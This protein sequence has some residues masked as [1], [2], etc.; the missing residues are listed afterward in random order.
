[1]RI[2][3]I[4]RPA[5]LRLIAAL[6]GLWI[7][8]IYLSPSLIGRR[9]LVPADLWARFPPWGFSFHEEAR[10]FPSNEVLYDVAWNV[11]PLIHMDRQAYFSGSWPL[12]NPYFRCGAPLL[13]NGQ[14]APFAPTN[15]PHWFLPWPFGFAFA[16]LARMTIAWLGAWLLGR[17]L[18]LHAIWASLLGLG[19]LFCPGL[20]SWFQH[21]NANVLIWFP[22][23]LWAAERLRQ[24]YATVGC[25][26]AAT[27]L[28]VIEGIQLCGGHFHSSFNITFATT[29][30][31]LIRFPFR[32]AG[33]AV[34][35]R[36]AALAALACGGILAAPAL[37]PAAEFLKGSYTMLER[38]QA[39][40]GQGNWVLQPRVFQLLL[41]PLKF[42]NQIRHSAFPWTGPVNWCVDQQYIGGAPWAL[43]LVGL[44]SLGIR[45]FRKAGLS[46]SLLHTL[47]SLLAMALI[48]ASMAYGWKPIQG[49]LVRVPP[50]S[51]NTNVH[52]AFVAQATVVIVGCL[53]GH[54]V[55]GLWSPGKWPRRIAVMT[56]VSVALACAAILLYLASHNLWAYRVWIAAA[57]VLA[58]ALC[59]SF[60][61]PNSAALLASGCLLTI[62]GADVLPVWRG[63]HVQTPFSWAHPQQ[64]DDEWAKLLK[65]IPNARILAQSCVFPGSAAFIGVTDTRAY[66]VPEP[67]RNGLFR[68]RLV[69]DRSE[70][71][72]DPGELGSV[73]K[74]R[75]LMQTGAQWLVTTNR[76][77]DGPAVEKADQHGAMFTYRL[78]IAPPLAEVFSPE[79]LSVVSTMMESAQ[80]LKQ[81]QNAQFRSV[82]VE[83][84]TRAA[85][86]LRNSGQGVPAKLEFPNQN[87]MRITSL[88][89]QGGI[90]VVRESYDR[91]WTAWAGSRKLAVK[92]ADLMF[93]AVTVPPGAT[94][95]VMKYAPASFYAGLVAGLIGWLTVAGIGFWN[96][97]PV[98]A[99]VLRLHRRP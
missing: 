58:V 92:P 84:R 80:M 2:G 43:A 26:R 19:L 16:A 45:A 11:A 67:M 37:L 66:D 93:M 44:L 97:A 28:A 36:L 15:L 14:S 32:P 33:D 29:A 64:A 78:K 94:A 91:N 17:R 8:L 65:S 81:A 69:A 57:G 83:D 89:P 73:P 46:W 52:F 3:R 23:L 56:A 24:E 96:T 1:M 31:L 48:P 6:G 49:L 30:Y 41:N 63:F 82:I 35:T 55:L 72:L 87:T 34:R 75:S 77:L 40:T 42:G 10:T 54:R 25:V 9:A 99:A 22:W 86:P 76:L 39:R 5:L 13:A 4:S 53:L 59:A 27:P 68:R 21:P 74:L 85:T 71:N 90:L 88:P 7:G 61:P 51:F 70:D 79:Q 98:R 12:W 18:C 20:M 50:F 47:V 38:S 95:V 60:L 62:W